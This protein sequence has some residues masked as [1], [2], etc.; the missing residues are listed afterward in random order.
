MGINGQ[1]VFTDEED[2]Q[3]AALDGHSNEAGDNKEPLAYY[4]GK[5]R[6]LAF[7]YVKPSLAK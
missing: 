2:Q 5:Y 6:H 3:Y 1:V 4:R 7:D